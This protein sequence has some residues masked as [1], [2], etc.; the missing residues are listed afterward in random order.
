MKFEN[1]LKKTRKIVTIFLVVDLLAFIVIAFFT[2]P[3]LN[4]TVEDAI[5]HFFPSKSINI[6]A[7]LNFGQR[8]ATYLYGD[9]YQENKSKSQLPVVIVVHG[10]SWSKGDKS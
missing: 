9:L 5:Q 8:G 3:D 4:Q 7:N 6:R 10:G 2:S 1:V